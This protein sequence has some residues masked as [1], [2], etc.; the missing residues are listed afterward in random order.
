MLYSDSI[1]TKNGSS[2]EFTNTS[3]K[4]VFQNGSREL[5]EC[6]CTLN[7]GLLQIK[8]FNRG[9]FVGEFLKVNINDSIFYSSYHHYGDIASEDFDAYPISQK[10]ILNTRSF[11]INDSIYGSVVFEGVGF[12][13]WL[14]DI[15]S[16]EV[17][18][19]GAF[20]C[21]LIK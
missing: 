19:N 10:L 6:S 11:S 13:S 21:K 16:F 9:G 4:V 12:S 17:D 20:K 14:K 18:V 2:L 7:N 8:L 1:N 5:E 3:P 15:T